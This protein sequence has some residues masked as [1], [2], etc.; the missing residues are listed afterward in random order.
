MGVMSAERPVAPVIP[1]PLPDRSAGPAAGAQDGPATGVPGRPRRRAARTGNRPV[2]AGEGDRLARA[3]PSPPVPA[4]S[5]P[6]PRPAEPAGYGVSSTRRPRQDGDTRRQQ[7]AGARRPAM[8][9][10][11]GAVARARVAAQPGVAGQAGRPARLAVSRRAHRAG[12]P[13]TGWRSAMVAQ[14]GTAQRV[15]VA[16]RPGRVRLT[17]RGRVVI[18]AVLATLALLVVGL[19]AA[20]RAQAASSGS[21][22]A[23]YRGMTRVVVQPGQTLWSIAMRAAPSA[24]PRAVV[25]RIMDVNGLRGTTIQPGRQLW[26]PHG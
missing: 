10:Q 1:L 13:D 7:P 12:R 25:Q 24:D 6:A 26:V 23:A 2:P 16:R 11:S 15:A 3:R 8:A 18:A 5:V 9:P 21:P 20:A 22:A 19:T 17:R 4:G 14:P